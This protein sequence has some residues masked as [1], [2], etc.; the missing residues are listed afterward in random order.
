MSAKPSE[1]AGRGIPAAAIETMTP[2]ARRTIAGSLS[3]GRMPAGSSRTLA[4]AI[5]L[6]R[7]WV[8]STGA[9]ADACA[10]QNLPV[11]PDPAAGATGS[12]VRRQNR[13]Q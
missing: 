9:L 12:A 13:N 2:E 10:R 3:E 4:G 11:P 7:P 6:N 1:A 8:E 5:G